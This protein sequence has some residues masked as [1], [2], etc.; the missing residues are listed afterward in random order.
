MASIVIRQAEATDLDR[1]TE[2]LGLLFSIEADFDFNPVK[3][4]CGL[5]MILNHAGAVILVAETEG[6]VLGMS[7]GQLTISTAQGGYAMLVEDVVVAEPWQG[8]GVG[9]ILIKGLEQWAK[10]RKV[11]RLQLLADCNNQEA[12]G[13]YKTLGWHRTELICLRRLLPTDHSE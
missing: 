6:Q 8:Q 12:L 7:S 1:L 9:K 13:F 5:Q 2:L 4:R 3:Q 10:A 11:E